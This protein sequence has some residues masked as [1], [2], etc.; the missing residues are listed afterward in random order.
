MNIINKPKNA[1]EIVIAA[2]SSPSGIYIHS[3]CFSFVLL[4]YCHPVH[5]NNYIMNQMHNFTLFRLNIYN[6]HAKKYHAPMHRK[7]LRWPIKA[8]QFSFKYLRTKVIFKIMNWKRSFP[9]LSQFFLLHFKVAQ[10]EW[11]DFQFSSISAMKNIMPFF[12]DQW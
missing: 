3:S 11:N 7:T 12:L 2:T 10:L 6:K 1:Y 5:N 9:R 8:Q 4:V